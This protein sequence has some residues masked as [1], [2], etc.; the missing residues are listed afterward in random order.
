MDESDPGLPN[1]QPA[2][3]CGLSCVTDFAAEEQGLGNL[4]VQPGHA[5]YGSPNNKVDTQQPVQQ[6][7][8]VLGVQPVCAPLPDF[9]T[10][11]G[12]DI[13]KC[14]GWIFDIMVI[15]FDWLQPSDQAE[16]K[17]IAAV[18]KWGN[19]EL[20][21]FVMQQQ[22]LKRACVRNN[23][24]SAKEILYHLSGVEL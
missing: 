3:T 24:E 12:M 19:T 21:A 6:Q 18:H 22:I 13:K 15:L 20:Q 9:D 2:D 17:M 5:T 4:D 11:T 8:E 23:T 16:G 1:Q 10:N 7:Q 14:L